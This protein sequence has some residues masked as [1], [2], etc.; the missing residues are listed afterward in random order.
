MN[1][2]G[3][4]AFAAGLVWRVELLLE[5]RL[6]RALKEKIRLIEQQEE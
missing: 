5:R 3:W 6:T 1:A 2:Y 4:L